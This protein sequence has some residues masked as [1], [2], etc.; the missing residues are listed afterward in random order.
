MTPERLRECLTLVR[1]TRR[2]LADALMCDERLIRRWLAGESTIP[3]GVAV[4]IETLGQFHARRGPPSDW[5][6]RS[7]PIY[8]PAA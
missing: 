2:G 1:W 8:Y 5:R 4:W 3:D 7:Q 6:R